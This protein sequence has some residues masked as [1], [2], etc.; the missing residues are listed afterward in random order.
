[1][2]GPI[3]TLPWRPYKRKWRWTPE[4]TRL[5]RAGLRAGK[6]PALL[7]KVIGCPLYSVK[8]KRRRLRREGKL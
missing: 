7:A 6:D 3:G 1:M 4:T 5:L 8:E 2:S